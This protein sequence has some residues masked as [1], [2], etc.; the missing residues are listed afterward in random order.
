MNRKVQSRAINSPGAYCGVATGLVYDSH[1]GTVAKLASPRNL[2]LY[3]G[4][5]R[6]SS[7]APIYFY[8]PH[9]NF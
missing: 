8:F 6:P 2:V 1:L 9:L 7:M 5:V 4:S 3:I